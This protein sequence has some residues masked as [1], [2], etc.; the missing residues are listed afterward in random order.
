MRKIIGIDFG[1]S[2]TIVYLPKKGI[3]Y[4]EPTVIAYNANNK[5]VVSTGYLAFKLLG[6]THNDTKVIRPIENGVISDGSFSVKYL[7]NVLR[8]LHLLRKCRKATLIVSR[9]SEFTQIEGTALR[10]VFRKL[11]CN[12]IMFYSASYLS[13]IGCNQ[14]NATTKG[15]FMINIGG[16]I[17]DMSVI[18]NGEV[19]LSKTCSFSGKKLDATIIRH[20][21]KNHQLIIS[22]KTAEYIKMK[23]GSIESYPENRLLEVSG[24][25][26]ISSLPHSVVISTSEIKSCLM[27]CI[28]PL[29]DAI[30]DCLEVI[31][32]DV[33]SD[34]I[35]SGVIICGGTSLLAGLRE[36][37]EN[38]LN[39]ACRVAPDPTSTTIQGIKNI[40]HQLLTIK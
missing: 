2:N 4:N 7:E 13:A 5:K 15:C 22:E 20:I 40:A 25:N 32:P 11:G 29:L 37:L 21:R 38:K 18:A 10:N 30:A 6:K 31:T 26:V 27:N 34:I 23:I 35:D 16:G 17:T 19:L 12:K 28:D 8:N 36:F 3:I 9:P 1:S 33:A 24:I 14:A 39:M